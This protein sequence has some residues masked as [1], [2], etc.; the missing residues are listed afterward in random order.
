M[1]KPSNRTVALSSARRLACD[2]MHFSQKLP[3]VVLERRLQLSEVGLARAALN[4]KP[5]W[6]AVFAKAYGIVALGRPE[7]RRA[8]MSFPWPRMFEHAEN[9]AVMPIERRQLDED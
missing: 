2:V 8:F 9:I 4:P 5:S 1:L 3:S 6:F 7:L